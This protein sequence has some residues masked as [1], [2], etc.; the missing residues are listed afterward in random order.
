MTAMK[1]LKTRYYVPSREDSFLQRLWKTTS[2]RRSP[3]F[4]RTLQIQT[5]TGCNAACVFCPYS[6]TVD[7]Q[8]RGAMKRELFEKIIDEIAEHGVR[9]ISPYLM[10][11]PFLDPA[12]IEKLVYIKK[13]IPRARLVVTTNGSRLTPTTIDELIAAD[14][15]HAL[16]ISFQGV[17]KEGY[18]ATMR[19][20]MVFEKTMDNI[21]ELI[22]KWHAAGGRERFRIVATMV[23]TSKTDPAQAVAFWKKKGIESKWTPLENRGGN[24]Q[25]ASKFAPKQREMKRFANCTRLFKQGYVMFNGDMVLCCTDYTRKVVLGNVENSSIKEI[26]NSGKALALRRLYAEGMMDEIPLCRDCEIS[27]S[28][29]DEEFG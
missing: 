25:A 6:T 8:P 28:T 2:R 18:E 22:E 19:G 10:N 14:A 3:G 26:W 5:Q 23:S 7:S 4:P 9:R 24:V 13:K 21:L 11:E 16:Y 15:L 1:T 20:S 12:I 29:G 17:E 27:D